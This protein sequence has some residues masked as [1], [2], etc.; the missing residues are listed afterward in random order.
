MLPAIGAA[1]GAGVLI[2]YL[3]RGTIARDDPDS[4]LGEFVRS[5][6]LW[7]IAYIIVQYALNGFM[8]INYMSRFYYGF[9]VAAFALMWPRTLS[10]RSAAF[11]RLFLSR[12]R[13]T[14]STLLRA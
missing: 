3:L 13:I 8:G 12:F 7:G 6:L 4:T 1:F 2:R 14:V 10:I 5:F 9:P 11:W